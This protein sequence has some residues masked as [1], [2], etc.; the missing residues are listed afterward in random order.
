MAPYT[1]NK[2]P[3]KTKKL[4]SSFTF[5]T[6]LFVLKKASKI[7]TTSANI[8]PKSNIN[9]LVNPFVALVSNSTKKTG[10]RVKAG[11][12]VYIYGNP[13]KIDKKTV[14]GGRVK[15]M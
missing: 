15:R 8:T 1:T 10:P 6:S 5:S 3:P 9:A 4:G 13:N 14:L 11:G 2:T 12:D 7:N